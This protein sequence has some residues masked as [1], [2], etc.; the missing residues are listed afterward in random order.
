METVKSLILEWSEYR[1]WIN[2][3]VILLIPVVIALVALAVARIIRGRRKPSLDDV[4]A[5]AFRSSSHRR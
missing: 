3:A 2:T 1:V 5:N 4:L